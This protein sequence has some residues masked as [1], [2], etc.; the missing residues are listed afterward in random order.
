M[1]LR[2]MPHQVHDVEP[3]HHSSTL[4]LRNHVYILLICFP[5]YVVVRNIMAACSIDVFWSEGSVT[6][7][8]RTEVV[9]ARLPKS[10]KFTCCIL[11]V[12]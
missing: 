6:F 3:H 11:F 12:V 8:Y 5:N 1:K 9:E 4:C 2:K 7:L 10:H